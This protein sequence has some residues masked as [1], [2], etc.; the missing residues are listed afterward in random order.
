MTK[1]EELQQAIKTAK[2]DKTSAHQRRAYAL[3]S[4]R[5]AREEYNAAVGRLATAKQ[6]LVDFDNGKGSV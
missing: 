4:V 5:R 3:S 2:T 1:R 6:A